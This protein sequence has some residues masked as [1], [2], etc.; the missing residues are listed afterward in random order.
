[1]SDTERPNLV[2]RTGLAI[3]RAVTFVYGPAEI[4]PEVDPIVQ[5]DRERGADTTP[6][7]AVELTERQQSYENLPRGKAE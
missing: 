2:V 3:K 1:M 5:L 4:R 6:K 7:P